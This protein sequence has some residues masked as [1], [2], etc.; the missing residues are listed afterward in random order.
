MISATSQADVTILVVS[1]LAGEFE[2]GIAQEGQTIK[3]ALVAFALGIKE[4]VVCVNKMGS[5]YVQWSETR[6][7]E[8][9][10]HLSASLQKIGYD[11]EKI[12]FVPLSGWEGQ[13][14]TNKC[15]DPLSS[16][17]QGPCLLEVLDNLETPKRPV[18]KP[19][20]VPIYHAYKI[21]GP[22]T[23]VVGK[24]QTGTLKPST[25][26][27]IGP[28]GLKAEAGSIKFF[29][30]DVPEAI[31]GNSVGIQIKGLSNRVLK[32]GDV[33]GESER[34][35][36]KPC[37]E[38]IAEITMLNHPTQIAKG[39]TPVI[40][41]HTAHVPCRFEELI[42]TIT[43]KGEII[44]EKPSYL[45]TGDYALVRMKPLKP[46][47]MEKYDDYPSLGRIIVRDQRMIV[48]A[49]VIKSVVKKEK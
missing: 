44:R 28:N 39:Y 7:N 40:D 41:C 19:L 31:S 38:F 47:C 26:I 25:A 4:M 5:G 14:L 30:K 12:P 17:Y 16:W 27:L 9:K 45:K 15:D 42:A 46:I 33:L 34:D 35:P 1:A 29:K 10:T 2:A 32:R 8:I 22:G 49:G 18:D 37:E 13:N 36:P 23:V 48:A 21:G 6:D 24:V 20:R 43:N 3:H 11:P